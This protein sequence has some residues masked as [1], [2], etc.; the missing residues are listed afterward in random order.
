VSSLG[1]TAERLRGVPGVRIGP[2]RIVVAASAAFNTT[3]AFSA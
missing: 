1:D 3:L 2:R